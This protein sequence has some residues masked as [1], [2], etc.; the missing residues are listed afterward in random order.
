MTLRAEIIGGDPGHAQ[1]RLHGI[2][3]EAGSLRL[4]IRRNQGP[5]T[6]LGSQGRW[7]STPD[8]WF[9]IAPGDR[10]PGADGIDV[11]I[12][13][14]IVDP[15]AASLGANAFQVTVETSSGTVSAPLIIPQHPILLASG[16]AGA[17]RPAPEPAAAPPPPP[18]PS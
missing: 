12:G 9:T 10:A 4:Q 1:L 3:P 16:A 17:P 15:G 18:A 6:Y 5:D 14:E 13:P 8:F 2:A 7:Q 11:A